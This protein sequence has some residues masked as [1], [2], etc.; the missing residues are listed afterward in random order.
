MSER[1]DRVAPVGADR[2]RGSLAIEA[3]ILVPAIAV[4]F[5]LVVI[6]GQLETASGSVQEAARVGAR[7][8]TLDYTAAESDQQLDQA[9]DAAVTQSL[10]ENG[11]SCHGLTVQATRSSLQTGFLPLRTVRVEVKCTVQVNDLFV[12]GVPGEMEFD[13]SFTSV[14]DYYRPQ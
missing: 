2:E 8:V 6:I 10:A 3:A 9:A 4:L 13:R 12:T 14:I 1:A 7:T 11:L 5:S